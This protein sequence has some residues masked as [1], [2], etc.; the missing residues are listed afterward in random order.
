MSK[1]PRQASMPNTTSVVTKSTKPPKS[2]PPI[3]RQLRDAISRIGTAAANCGLIASR[4]NNNPAR[5]G[6]RS[7]RPSAAIISAALSN[8]FWPMMP[9]I[10]TAGNASARP[11]APGMKRRT[12]KAKAPSENPAHAIAAIGNDI[13]PNGAIRMKNGGGYGN[14][15]TPWTGAARNS[16]A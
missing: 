12:T 11:T 13:R 15:I 5:N 3:A 10:N 2:A 7:R 14:D 9:Q 1:N 8:P 6:R 16:T 4:L